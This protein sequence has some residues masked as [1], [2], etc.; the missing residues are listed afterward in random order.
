MAE[1]SDR[2]TR[3]GGKFQ[4]LTT[5]SQR[6]AAWLIGK[7]EKTLRDWVDFPRNPDGTYNGQAIVKYVVDREKGDDSGEFIDN[8]DRLAAAQ[9]E[10]VEMENMIRRGEVC[11]IADIEKVFADHVVACRA[12]L[13][14]MAAKLTPQLVGK[15][16]NDISRLIRAEV[17]TALQELA[18]Y[19]PE[20]AGS[21]PDQGVEVVD[22]T[23]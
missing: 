3:I 6:Q 8:R 13:L 7:S 1:E 18:D 22:A 4:S 20:E 16:T 15:G 9:A 23:A 17:A 14:S 10:R 5:L 11:V 12:K 19:Q 21:E 2:M